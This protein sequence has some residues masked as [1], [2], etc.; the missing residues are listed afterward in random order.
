MARRKMVVKS[1]GSKRVESKGAATD[2]KPK[3]KKASKS[4]SEGGKNVN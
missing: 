4:K 2:A 3:P 1:G